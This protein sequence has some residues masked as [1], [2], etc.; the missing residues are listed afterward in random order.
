MK[1]RKRASSGGRRIELRLAGVLI[2]IA[3]GVG[4]FA[5]RTS[6]PSDDRR[7]AVS[8]FAVGDTGAVPGRLAFVS[9]Q[10]AVG[11]ALATE[12]ER[13]PVDALVLLGDLFYDNGLRERELVARVRGN[14]VAPYCRFVDLSGPRSDEVRGACG[15]GEAARARVRP[16]Y[17]VL[18]NHDVTTEESRRLE[19][20]AIAPFVA[21]WQLSPEPASWIALSPRVSLVLFDSNR[22][23]NGGDT[24][25]LRDAVR[26][27]PGPWRILVAHHPIGTRS[28]GKRRDEY[29]VDVRKA[30]RDAGVPVQLM[31]AGHEH[32]LQVVAQDDPGPR[33]V[34]VSGAGSRPRDVLTKSRTRLFSF[35]ELGFVRVDLLGEGEGEHLEVTLFAAPHWSSLLGFPAE[36]L[37]RWSLAIDGAAAVEPLKIRIVEAG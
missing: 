3:L 35:E 9:R 16:I 6:A 34:V 22:L 13:S 28:G 17:A 18:G 7:P 12:D 14:I 20:G 31:L 5:L 8:F 11:S 2:A 26:A 15:A 25:P 1:W 30:V 19:V 29:T 37:G 4:V 24:T 33:L 10:S 21:N 36:V 32:N 23:Q 27:A